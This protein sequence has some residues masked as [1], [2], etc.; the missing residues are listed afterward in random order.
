M[1][2][3]AAEKILSRK[4]GEVVRAGD[5]AVVPVDGAMATDAT[6]PFAIKAFQGM[7]GKSVWAPERISLILDH[8]TPPP[9]E[10]VSTLHVM[11][12]D[13]ARQHGTHFYDVGEGI[14][15]QL[16][17]ENGHAAPGEL[18]VG[19]DSHTPT[20]GALGAF[21]IGVGS[22]DLAAVML[23]GRIWLKVPRTVRIELGGS[24]RRGTYAKDVILHLVGKLG[25]AGATYDAVEF[26][27]AATRSMTLASR[28]VLANMVAE[29]GAKTALVD[30][31]DLQLP[32]ALAG[33][34]FE[35]HGPDEGAEYRAVHHL[36]V[37]DLAA[38]VAVPHSPDAVR[39]VREVAGTKVQQ[40]FIG[41]CTNS[42]LEDLHQAAAILRGKRVAPGVRLI[43]ATAS[44]RIL[45]EGMADG[46]V[47]AL[48]EA[49]A[50]FI[51]SGCGPC[52]G[53]HQGVPGD[54]ETVISSTNRNFRGRMGNP[55]ANV[56][57]GSPA[58]VAAAA[59]AG[60]IVDP[61]QFLPEVEQ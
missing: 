1:P 32:E 37:S 41:S 17:M 34:T 51:T 49:G 30:T 44:R 56:Y 47:Q 60:E 45:N 20:L 50:S 58:V 52:V 3:T 53:T 38:Q 61:A 55:N 22:T 6:A 42:R 11:M 19:A 29:M 25:I 59:L 27:G 28:M 13:F 46:T 15:H 5:I 24:L 57:L 48:S 14:C 33:R 8:A 10:R 54:G 26:G 39:D 35:D 40:A 12:R 2:Q 7:G 4:A 31:D 9:N 18:F 16:M 36:D 23:T 43:I 21:A